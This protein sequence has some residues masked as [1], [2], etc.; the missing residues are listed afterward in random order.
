MQR[1]KNDQKSPNT[2]RGF[3]KSAGALAAGL[4]LVGRSRASAVKLE[5]LALNG[6]PKAVKTPPDSL[7]WGRC[8]PLYGAAEQEAVLEL[9]T[10][11][12]GGPDPW[13]R[14]NSIPLL[15]KEWKEH[16]KAPYVRA[17]QKQLA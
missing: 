12:W 13:G 17:H 1:N 14:S 9:A 3:L 4:S 2:R 7:A 11:P 16:F 15:E 6:G 8:W 10:N 5:T